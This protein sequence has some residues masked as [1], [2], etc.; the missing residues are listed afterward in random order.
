[1][2]GDALAGKYSGQTG[3][4]NFFPGNTL[5][6]DTTYE[7]VVAAGG[8]HDCA[9]N[10]VE[11]EFTSVFSTGPEIGFLV[12]TVT[13]SH[14]VNV[15]ERV[16]FEV[17]SC[18][19][20]D[21]VVYS[22]D[23]GDGTAPTPF[24]SAPM[25]SHTYTAPGHHSVILLAMSGRTQ[26]RATVVQTVT[27]PTTPKRPTHATSIFLDESRDR[28][29][30]VNPDNDTVTA[31]A[32][33]TFAKLFERPVG[34]GPTTLALAPDDTIWVVNQVDA[35]ISVIGR[36]DGG[37]EETIDLPYGSQPHGIAFDPSGTAAYVT[38]EATG[39]LARMDPHG[40]T[41]LN[42]VNVGGRPRGLAI[43]HDDN[44]IF[45]A[46]F[47]SPQD[48]GEVVE[49]G[50]ESFEVTRVFDLAADPG[51]DT[52]SGGRGV[53]NYLLSL[54]ISPDG[55]RIWVPS[56]KDNA[57]R[58]SFLSGESL[59]FQSTVRTIVSQI[60]LLANEENLSARRDLNNR[61]LASA[62][63]FTGR[64][65]F[66]FVTTLGSNTVDVLDAYSGQTVT[67]LTD[68]GLAPRGLALSADD[69]H[70][71]VHNYL[72][73]EV[74]VHDV[75]GVARGNVFQRLATIATVAAE[76]LAPEVLLGKRIFYN[77]AD[78]RMARD[79]YISCAACHLDGGSDHR[80]WDFTDRG[81]G[82]RNT[83]ELRGRAGM[84][85]GPVHWS[86]NFDEI[87]DFEHDM[88]QAFQGHGFLSD[89]EFL[90]GTRN[91]P[92]GDPKAGTSAELD[93]LAAYVSSLRRVP[94]SPFRNPDGSRTADAL[95]GAEIFHSEETGCGDCHQGSRF[96]DSR[97]VQPFLLHDVGTIRASSGGRLGGE[98]DGIDTPTLR[99]VWATA[100]Y[101]HDGSAG[102]LHDVLT[103][104]N[105]DDL[106][107]KTSQLTATEI[108]QVIAYLLQLE[109]DPGPV[110]RR[111]N[112]NDDEGYDLSDS[113]AM[114]NTLFR[115]TESIVCFDAADTND[116]G[117]FNISDPIYA[118][119]WF[120][121]GADPIPAPGP[122]LCGPDPTPD[123]LPECEDSA[124]PCGRE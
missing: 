101:L 28:V 39:E 102:T 86:A 31:I 55:Q 121:L 97:L 116:D 63:A 30:N 25:A 58:G 27:L 32:A 57:G 114:I 124:T 77:S 72:S 113:V 18:A 76:K 103:S 74:T 13:E 43:A 64:G 59:T 29:W 1:V 94:A 23:F 48:H 69:R 42:R 99:G 40:R 2:G 106:H 49:V 15:N 98:L 56:K 21:P 62:V 111:G 112:V 75:T 81:E 109:E 92:L 85:H 91:T 119:K 12:C 66:A 110:F 105:P 104:A 108:D 46:R 5:D 96:T 82:L 26:S 47:V 89:E 67:S 16:T 24:S 60:D 51:P 73:R 107:G 100:P 11:A 71:F 83:T 9:A 35:T 44:R 68:L 93:A 54:T 3:I 118:L 78:D 41:I 88:R 53:P 36:D 10:A 38:L 80:V 33:T 17:E 117:R 45:V 95:A 52:E 79:N 50:R 34:G 120:F 14:P 20:Q 61:A 84:A 19:S 122:Q 65:D 123:T 4:V 22:W 8:I 6:P 70:L 37:L 7:V 87:Q 90:S 115:G